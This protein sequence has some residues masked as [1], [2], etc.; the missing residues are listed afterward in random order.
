MHFVSRSPQLERGITYAVIKY[1]VYNNTATYNN[2]HVNTVY[3]LIYF[4]IMSGKGGFHFS[5]VEVHFVY[6]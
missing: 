4:M 6:C 3:M 5:F 1:T 2:S